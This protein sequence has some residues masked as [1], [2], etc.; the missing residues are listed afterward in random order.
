MSPYP[1]LLEGFCVCLRVAAE[2]PAP[3]AIATVGGIHFTA[4]IADEDQFDLLL[5]SRHVSDVRLSDAATA[6]NAD[7]GKLVEVSQ[8]D[9]AGLHAA[10]GE[11]GHRAMRLIGHRAVGGI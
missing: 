6:E 1:G 3:R 9:R 8:G 7:V 4:A 2:R 5:E 10:H 11:T